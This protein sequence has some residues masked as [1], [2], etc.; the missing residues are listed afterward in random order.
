MAAAG[1]IGL[2]GIGLAH[3]RALEPAATASVP[4]ARV[5]LP[6]FSQLVTQNGQAVVNI[7]VS[8]KSE[9]AGPGLRGG[10]D[11]FGWFF[12]DLPRRQTP[13]RGV[14]SGFIVS[15]DGYILTNA[16]VVDGADE[17]TVRMSD[18]RE[19]KARV[20][21]SDSQTDVAVI[22][23]DATG[24]PTVRLGDSQAVSVG[25]WVVAI[26][27][28]Y[29]LESTVT[30]GIVSA[31]SRA[32]PSEGYVPFIQTD[33]A[34]N[35][36][37]SGGPL[38]DLD[39]RVIGINSQ[40][41]SRTGGWQGLSFAIHIDVAIRVKDQLISDGKDTR[42]RLGV[43]IQ[44]MS[45]PL[46]KSFG[47]DK[48]RGAAVTSVEP[49]S[50]AARAG[51]K[52]GDVILALDGKPVERTIDLA[53]RV[54]ERKPG[55][56]VRLEIWRDGS[57]QEI[58]A[59]LGQQQTKQLAAAASDTDKGRLGVAVRSLEKS[60]AAAQGLDGGLVVEAADGAAARAGIQ[61]GDVIV[62]MNGRPVDKPAQ[63]RQMLEKAGDRIAISV[64]RGD[65]RLFVP[66]EL[67]HG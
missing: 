43:G 1:M 14:G 48:P 8:K 59:K 55:S 67:E 7:S 20:V 19:M 26:G 60:E 34:V 21:G 57:R 2:G 47:L 23:V 39:G 46:A 10:D 66:V 22:K 35:P 3:S 62:S 27:S 28:P 11:P 6:D 30:A 5:A 65:A 51:L 33:V 42:G 40:I 52:A 54:A 61:P 31:T 56:E 38:F 29:G 4:A 64:K 24:L 36:G 16:H 41:Y 37:N 53:R 32:L 50:A 13:V 63:L 58:A 12:R 17:V 44:E 49:D 18:R 45:E 15:A 25:Q 9:A